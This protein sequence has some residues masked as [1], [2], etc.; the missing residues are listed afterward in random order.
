MPHHSLTILINFCEPIVHIIRLL[1]GNSIKYRDKQYKNITLLSHLF[2]FYNNFYYFIYKNDTFNDTN[3]NKIIVDSI[4]S[5]IIEC[6]LTY[7]QPFIARPNYKHIINSLFTSMYR[8]LGRHITAAPFN[9]IPGLELLKQLLPLPLPIPLLPSI[10]SVNSIN[11]RDEEEMLNERKLTSFH[12]EPLFEMKCDNNKGEATLA[13][14][15]RLLC[16]SKSNSQVNLKLKCICVQ[17][18]DLSMRISSLIFKVLFDY[19]IELFTQ[20]KAT[21]TQLEITNNKSQITNGDDIPNNTQI[22]D[23]MNEESETK[24][25]NLERDYSI[26][27]VQLKRVILFI[28]SLLQIERQG[29]KKNPLYSG[30]IELIEGEAKVLQSPLVPDKQISLLKYKKFLIEFSDYFSENGE[31]KDTFLNF[32]HSICSKNKKLKDELKVV[33]E[34][35]TDEEQVKDEL[36]IVFSNFSDRDYI[37]YKNIWIDNKTNQV[38]SSLNNIEQSTEIDEFNLKEILKNDNDLQQIIKNSAL[39]DSEIFSILNNEMENEN[40]VVNNQT[41]DSL[42]NQIIDTCSGKKYKAPI[43]G[44]QINRTSTLPNTK[45]INTNNNS[46]NNNNNNK[47]P[48]LLMPPPQSIIVNN[49]IIPSSLMMPQQQQQQ[50]QTLN[51]SNNNNNN[52]S[53]GSNSLNMNSNANRF[54]VYRG[55]QPNTSRPPSVHVDDFNRFENQNKHQGQI[56][57]PKMN[58]PLL[59]SDHLQ[60]QHH[61]QQQ[62]ILG[63]FNNNESNFNMQNFS[64]TGRT[65]NFN[66]LTSIGHATGYNSNS[67]REEFNNSLNENNNNNNF[68]IY[69]P[70]Q[71][72]Q[73]QM[74][75]HYFG[76]QNINNNGDTSN[77]ISE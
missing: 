41:K 61:Q 64:N 21:K 63:Q 32:I 22:E 48:L 24:K 10:K 69:H 27:R 77:N 44:G 8:E 37:K 7:T 73:Q 46:N 53:L 19:A 57:L 13:H 71:Q 56:Y 26:V 52:S 5:Q 34:E 39:N 28:Q 23:E 30:C 49:G 9:T 20:L 54:D 31:N 16:L 38:E 12:L 4:N 60:H 59:N 35:T 6:L 72:Q 42:F 47:Q 25:D 65:V 74:N 62:N 11:S 55:R 29:T 33:S 36:N 43:R 15:I 75:T 68:D 2:E 14:T 17:L 70:Q 18:S 67:T 51:D 45:S 58:Q 3:R 40:S 50:Q 76:H 1:L 66:N